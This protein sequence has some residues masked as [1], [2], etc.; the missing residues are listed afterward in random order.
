[1]EPELEA[2]GLSRNESRIYLFL[3]NK[4]TSTTGPII[5]ETG[6]ANSRVYDS[7]N[8]LVAKGLV[9]Y[10]VQ[11]DGKHFTAADPSKFIELEQE[12]AKRLKS[13]VPQLQAL[14][15]L[16]K[17]ETETAVYEGFEGWKTA[18]KKVVDDCPA[19]G[20]IYITAFS[21]EP[22]KL[23]SLRTFLFNLNLKSAQKKQRLKIILESSVRDTLGKD[24]E[25]ERYSEVRYMP[26]GY[27]APAA[28]DI[29]EDYV[30][31]FVWGE[32]PLAFMIK[33]RKIAENFKKHHQFLWSIAETPKTRKKHR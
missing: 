33:N 30:Y 17:E 21:E 12:R 3:L 32:K 20:T 31:M 15:G 1:M 25:S 11:K 6:I 26:E 27:I 5:K 22:Y 4:G 7:L 18:F 29:F 16:E 23:E 19:N 10:N 9:T 14:R 2:L 13:L 8:S 28:M 24:R